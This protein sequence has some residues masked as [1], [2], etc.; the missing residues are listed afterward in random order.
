LVF[1]KYFFRSVS[2]SF[3]SSTLRHIASSSSESDGELAF[4][5]PLLS[6]NFSLADRSIREAELSG[7]SVV[8][9]VSTVFVE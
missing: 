6:S 8:I 9:Q 4:D 5:A 1:Q 3:R 2:S 7:R